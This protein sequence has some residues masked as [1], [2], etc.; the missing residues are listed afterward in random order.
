MKAKTRQRRHQETTEN[1]S[2]TASCL[3]VGAGV[4]RDLHCVDLIDS[5]PAG[6]LRIGLGKPLSSRHQQLR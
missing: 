4:R 2:G 5:D 3:D 1:S 6:T